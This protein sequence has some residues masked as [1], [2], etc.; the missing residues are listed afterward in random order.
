MG[1]FNRTSTSKD[2]KG[3]EVTTFKKYDVVKLEFHTPSEHQIDSKARDLEVEITL[4]YTS[5]DK[6]TTEN[7][8]L[9]LL[10]DEGKENAE[11]KK[12]LDAESGFN[13]KALVDTDKIKDFYQYTGSKTTPDCDKMDR[14][15]K[16]GEG[17]VKSDQITKLKTLYNQAVTSKDDKKNARDIQTAATG[18]TITE[19]GNAYA[20]FFSGLL[21]FL[22]L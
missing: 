3:K 15:I 2:D 16:M 22:V 13:L 14:I 10:F 20:L 12:A 6:K 4:K 8:T 18:L 19:H 5:A 17:T 1:Y 9:S 21:F 11:I 7:M